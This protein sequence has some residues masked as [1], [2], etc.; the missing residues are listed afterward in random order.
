MK[1]KVRTSVDSSK[2]P[3]G[4]RVRST[5]LNEGMNGLVVGG[6]NFQSNVLF[7]PEHPNASPESHSIGAA[8]VSEA[9]GGANVFSSLSRDVSFHDDSY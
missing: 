5:Y 2:E 4:K 9:K 6:E 3:V 8:D 7:I 1:L